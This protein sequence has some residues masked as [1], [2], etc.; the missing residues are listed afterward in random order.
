MCSNRKKATSE[1]GEGGVRKAKA[2]RQKRGKKEDKEEQKKKH[3]REGERERWCSTRGHSLVSG[4]LLKSTHER[5]Y[6]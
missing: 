6:N 5:D 4:P 1:K 2:D 3:E